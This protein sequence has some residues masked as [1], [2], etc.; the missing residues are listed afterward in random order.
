MEEKKRT[1]GT[2]LNLASNETAELEIIQNEGLIDVKLIY[3]EI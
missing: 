1:Y 3:E 2:T